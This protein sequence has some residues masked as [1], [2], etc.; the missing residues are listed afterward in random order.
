MVRKTSILVIIGVAMPSLAA[1]QDVS[2]RW[3][4]VD[5]GMGVWTLELERVSAAEV[6]GSITLP[7]GSAELQE[8]RADEG[9]NDDGR[10]PSHHVLRRCPRE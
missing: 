5:V 7:M 10:R 2:G 3:I 4:G 9:R 6:S 1:A 8:G